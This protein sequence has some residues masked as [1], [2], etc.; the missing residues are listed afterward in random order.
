MLKKKP[1]R[2]LIGISVLSLALFSG[3]CASGK[4]P[5][6]KIAD[7]ESAIGRARESIAA[8]Y[9]PLE[10]KFAEDKL[11]EAKALMEKEEYLPAGRLL[12][13]ALI[14]A[15]LAEAKSRSVQKRTEAT[16]IRDSIDSLRKEIEFKSQGR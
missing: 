3:A 16:E 4:P 13:E 10:L 5:V 9:A 1:I 6:A 11:T 8:T 15:K 7:V 14:D 12:D 2:K